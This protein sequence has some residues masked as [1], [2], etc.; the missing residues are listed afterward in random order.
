[1]PKAWL[2]VPF[3]RITIMHKAGL[4]CLC[5]AAERGAVKMNWFLSTHS[6]MSKGADIYY[7]PIVDIHWWCAWEL[8]VYSHSLMH[9]TSFSVA[10]TNILLF[11]TLNMPVFFFL[12]SL[13]FIWCAEY[14]LKVP[15]ECSW[16][17]SLQG[18]QVHCVCSLVFR[19]MTFYLNWPFSLSVCVSSPHLSAAI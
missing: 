9:R 8:Q 5:L 3:K 12:P 2:S 11:V 16:S 10:W 15:Q 1:M 17:W 4:R 6:M 14:W 13:I 7:G 18:Q 19:P